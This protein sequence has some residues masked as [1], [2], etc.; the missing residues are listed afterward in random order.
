MT[1]GGPIPVETPRSHRWQATAARR[2]ETGLTNGS[3]WASPGCRLL[4]VLPARVQAVPRNYIQ[5][6]LLP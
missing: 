4:S 6:L 3:A 2:T 5:F 1:Q